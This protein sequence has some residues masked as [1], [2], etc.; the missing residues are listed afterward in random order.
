MILIFD[1]NGQITQTTNSP[2]PPGY[3]ETIEGLGWNYLI[4]PDDEI[5]Y[6]RLYTEQYVAD[7]QVVD[8]PRLDL[9]AQ[10]SLTVG[11]TVR[12]DV[13]TGTTISIDGSATPLPDNF[14]EIEG[15]MPAQYQLQFT[16]WPYMAANIE[17]TVH[18]A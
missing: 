7:G 16:N 18:E 5:D 17:V 1:D 10:I 3:I 9:P 15:E 12:L 11:E 4:R 8:R 13:P 6:V 14:V 2:I